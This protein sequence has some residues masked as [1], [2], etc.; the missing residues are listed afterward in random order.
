LALQQIIEQQEIRSMAVN[1]PDYSRSVHR[2]SAVAASN[3]PLVFGLFV[4]F[5]RIAGLKFRMFDQAQ[6][7]PGSHP[8]QPV[9]VRQ[10]DDMGAKTV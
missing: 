6:H 2:G 5:D 7:V 3:R 1:W 9:A 8:R 10:G 4:E